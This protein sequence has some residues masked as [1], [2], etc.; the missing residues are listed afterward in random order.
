MSE[1]IYLSLGSN[2][3]DRQSY[4]EKA[5]QRLADLIGLELL[6]RSS[7]YSSEPIGRSED[8]PEFLN[9]VL[10]INCNL[11]PEQLLDNTERLE[12]AL[13]RTS[14]GFNVNRVI[15]IDI[16]LFGNRIFSN[17]RL[18]IP[19]PRMNERAFVLLPLLEI[20]SKLV[21]PHSGNL[22]S[23]ELKK[24]PDQKVSLVRESNNA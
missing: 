24:L 2:L 6:A 18:E 19:H 20:D 23:D 13:G 16:L 5:T 1:E 17:D 12:Q 8:C 7:I 11:P 14:K 15:D 9:M 3:G 22:F 21:N 10:K 4:L